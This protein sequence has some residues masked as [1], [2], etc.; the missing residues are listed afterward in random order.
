MLASA[1]VRLVA[2]CFLDIFTKLRVF[3]VDRLGYAKCLYLN[4]DMALF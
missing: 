4:V 3:Q 2:E 1:I